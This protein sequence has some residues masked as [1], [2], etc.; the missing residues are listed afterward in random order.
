MRHERL[1]A[2]LGRGRLRH[3]LP[4]AVVNAIVLRIARDLG[5]PTE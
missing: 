3:V 1:L 5:P 4:P 2:R